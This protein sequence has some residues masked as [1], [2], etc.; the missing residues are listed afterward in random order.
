MEPDRVIFT[1]HCIVPIGTVT[2]VNL[3]L[4]VYSA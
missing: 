4:L 3:D 1:L 2:K